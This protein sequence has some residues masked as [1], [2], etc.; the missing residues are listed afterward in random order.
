M[1]IF[2]SR[3]NSVRNGF[4]LYLASDGPI[5]ADSPTLSGLAGLCALAQCL[6]PAAVNP[7]EASTPGWKT[8][9]KVVPGTS[10][11][12]TTKLYH[13]RLEHHYRDPTIAY[14]CR[15][16]AGMGSIDILE[17][18]VPRDKRNAGAHFVKWRSQCPEDLRPF[19][20]KLAAV[21]AIQ[22]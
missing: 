17:S 7:S 16:T 9:F 10:I 20:G 6:S 1:P 14:F 3:E 19:V 12:A 4:A 8:I 18:R 21:F 2:G 13:P 22:L 5:L 11:D 15:G